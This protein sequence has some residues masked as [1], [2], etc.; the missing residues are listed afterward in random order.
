MTGSSSH[1]HLR[2]SGNP[3]GWRDTSFTTLLRPPNRTPVSAF[4][5]GGNVL[6]PHFLFPEIG[7]QFF[8]LRPRMAS[9]RFFAAKI[10]RGD[11]HG[12]A[13]LVQSRAHSGP[14]TLL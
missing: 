14:N 1:R 12:A 13:H 6:A 8:A 5:H 7:C 4:E 9:L 2:S 10:R 3:S 11:F